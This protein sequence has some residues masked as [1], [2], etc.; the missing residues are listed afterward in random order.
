MLYGHGFAKAGMSGGGTFDG[1]GHLIGMICGG[2]QQNETASVPLP[3]IIA[4]YKEIMG[5]YI[6][7][8]GI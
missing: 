3:S 4:A 2:T 7:G 5:D 6:S 8:E 1:Y